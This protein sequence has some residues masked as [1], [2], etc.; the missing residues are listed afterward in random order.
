[1]L[2][3]A[4][5]LLLSRHLAAVEGRS[6]SDAIKH[7][8]TR[9]AGEA[10]GEFL[11]MLVLLMSANTSAYDRVEAVKKLEIGLRVSGVL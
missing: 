4:R 5:T 8:A 6:E 11:A 7:T 2:S 3:S 1:M 9:L 10:S